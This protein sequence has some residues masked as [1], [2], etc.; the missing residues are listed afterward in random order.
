MAVDT[1]IKSAMS[2][3]IQVQGDAA[4]IHTSLQSLS[5]FTEIDEVI[6]SSNSE[7]F[8]QM[9]QRF[10]SRSKWMKTGKYANLNPTNASSL[11]F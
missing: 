10:E 4:S 11:R 7:E 5:I 2:S 8:E 3:L 9:L 1:G 6:S